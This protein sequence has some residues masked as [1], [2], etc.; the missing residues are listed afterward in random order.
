MKKLGQHF[1]TNKSK[2]NKIVLALEIKTGDTI[3][4]IG[5]GHG[6]LTRELRGAEKETKIIAIEKDQELYEW[7]TI[8]WKQDQNISFVLGD[9][10]EILPT[11]MV[12]PESLNT[13]YK[14]VGNIPYY[15]TGRLLRLFSELASKPGII[16]LT[17]Q[18]EVAERIVA[19]LPRMNLLAASIQFWAKPEIIDFIP[20]E[21]FKPRPEVDSAI[22]K[23]TPL[24]K[25]EFVEG[26][27]Y[28]KL[29]KILFKQPR[30]TILN[31]LKAGFPD[32]VTKDSFKLIEETI[33]TQGR[34]QDLDVKTIKKLSQMLYN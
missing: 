2:I 5:P 30:K 7:L 29:I 3:I 31:N 4:E 12:N 15:L 22:I 23:L 8:A 6:E 11:L 14:I 1:L 27:N 17:I 32:F 34:P 28:Y 33:N 25:T 13:N 20:R 9:A 21:D 10:L 24:G 19:K 18:K 26:K 16:V